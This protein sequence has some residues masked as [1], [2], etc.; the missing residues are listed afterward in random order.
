MNKELRKNLKPNTYN[1]EPCGG[2]VT[3]LV[4]VFAGVFFVIV[5]ALSGFIFIQNKVQIAKENREKAF[6]LAEAGLDYY[7]WFLAHF[8]SDLQDGTGVSGPYVHSYSDPEGGVIGNFSLD[9]TGNTECGVV[10][11]IDITSTGVTDNDPTLERVLFGSYARPS[12]AEYAFILNSDA[13]AAEQT[14]LGR[15]HSNGGIRMDATN[16]SLVSSAVSSW[17]CNPTFGCDPSSTE[18]GVFGLGDDALWQY[19]VPQIDFAGIT[20][21][22]V[23][24]KALSQSDGI[25]LADSGA[26]GYHIYLQSD[27]TLDVY[28][29]DSTGGGDWGYSSKWGWEQEYY[30]ILSET[31][32]QTYTPPTDCGLVFVEDM[33]WLEGT[34]NG[35]ITIASADLVNSNI[36]TDVLLMNNI[37]YSTLDGSDGI[38]VI[39]EEDVLMP[40][41]VPDDMTIRGIY[42]AQSGRFG[43]NYYDPATY[44]AY[45]F[46]NSLKVNGSVISNGRTGTKWLCGSPGVY[47]SGFN[48]RTNSYDQTQAKNPPP[49]TPY[50][51]DDFRFVEWREETL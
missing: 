25:Y 44:P 35:K 4:L 15:Y 38:T 41:Q 50:T 39:S 42:I 46:R 27:G 34:V 6:Q 19:P 13:W 17:T 12:I 23:S 11:S 40:L 33:L 26:D 37:E 48:T 1:P 21:D 24:M 36:E 49:L 45:S 7:K 47:C 43:R 8:P 31:F 3:M 29:V 20:A 32:L 16:E 22:L 10:T 18:N 9:I 5:S 28:R 14:I 51:S 2:Y 30:N